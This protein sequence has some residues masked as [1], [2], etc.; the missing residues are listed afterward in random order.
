VTEGHGPIRASGARVSPSAGTYAGD[1]CRRCAGSGPC[2]SPRRSAQQCRRRHAWARVAGGSARTG[3]AHGQAVASH[4]AW[5]KPGQCR[6]AACAHRKQVSG[7]TAMPPARPGLPR[8]TTGWTDGPRGSCPMP[9]ERAPID[10]AKAAS[11]QMR[12]QAGRAAARRDHDRRH[13][14]K[15]GCRVAS[16]WLAGPPRAEVPGGCPASRWRRR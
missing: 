14:G 10:A 1:V 7:R 15:K 6:R 3:M 5:A 9:L 8:C 12:N 4:P 11:C 16:L 2:L 13:Q